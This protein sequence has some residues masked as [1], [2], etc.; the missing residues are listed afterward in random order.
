LPL[1]RQAFQPT[2]GLSNS[3]CCAIYIVNEN[4]DE[5]KIAE[6]LAHLSYGG[7]KLKH[8]GC[9]GLV[10]NNPYNLL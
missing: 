2:F 1:T 8:G 10:R 5:K 4:G 3:I 6:K 7:H 9:E